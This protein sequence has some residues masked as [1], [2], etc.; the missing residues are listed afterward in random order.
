MVQKNIILGLC[1]VALVAVLA[2]CGGVEEPDV[3]YENA[4]VSKPEP[5][6]API[7][8]KPAPPIAEKPKP[9][10]M[11][12]DLCEAK[13]LQYLVGKHRRDIPVPV[14]PE[15]RRVYCTTCMVTMDYNPERQNI[16]FDAATGIIKSVG[17]G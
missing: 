3:D 12:D 6:P 15:K 2:A 17:C 5:A 7:T 9:K 13:S 1:L 16:V 4:P 14:H 8:P 10:P 11:N